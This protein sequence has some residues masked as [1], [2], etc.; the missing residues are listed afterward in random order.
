KTTLGA[1]AHQVAAIVPGLKPFI[2]DT[3]A[4]LAVE[5]ADF[6]TFSK[7]FSD[8]TRCLASDN[9]PVVFMFDDLQWADDKSL[10]LIDQF[11][12]HNN[13]EAFYM[14]V[15]HRPVTGAESKAFGAFIEKFR[16]LRRRFHEI[17]LL[18]LEA[19]ATR[20]IVGNMLGSP[21]S[22]RDDLIEYLTTKSAGNP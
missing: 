14:I 21:E 12:S 5:D 6:Q 3:D 17:E 22:I 13:H 9:Q 19:A 2:D 4:E 7:G 20:E 1:A 11:F 18:P 10:Q 16:K 15:T 8:F